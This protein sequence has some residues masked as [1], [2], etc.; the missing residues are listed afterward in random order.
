MDIITIGQRFLAFCPTAI[1]FIDM[2]RKHYSALYKIEDKEFALIVKEAKSYA[3]ILR[4]VNLAYKGGNINTVKRRIELLKLDDSHIPK[5][6]GSNRHR[7]FEYRQI[8]LDEAIKTRFIKNSSDRT[9]SI[10]RLILRFH[11]I[12]YKCGCGNTGE[13]NGKKL[14]LQLDH[15]DGNS[16]NHSLDNLRFICPNCH[17]QTE[18]FAGKNCKK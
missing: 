10:K 11:L 2:P 7:K 15:K 1:I 8:S 6:V 18:N 14:V 16:S 5:G 4:R 17:S 9:Y 3:D 12:P 13:W